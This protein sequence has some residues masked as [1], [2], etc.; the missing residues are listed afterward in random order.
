MGA[1]PDIHTQA[2]EVARKLR[3]CCDCGGTGDPIFKWSPVLSRPCRCS[4]LGTTPEAVEAIE[5]FGRELLEWAGNRKWHG[6]FKGETTGCCIH[7]AA[8][9]GPQP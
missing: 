8:K 5:A 3:P 4:G 9:K 2:I 6:A 7:D 1:M